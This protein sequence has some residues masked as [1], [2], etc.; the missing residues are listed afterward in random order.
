MDF[1]CVEFDLT[2]LR[3]FARWLWGVGCLGCRLKF[4]L[5]L[6]LRDFAFRGC[7]KDEQ[8]IPHESHSFVMGLKQK[9]KHADAEVGMVLGCFQK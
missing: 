5:A 3:S 1:P 7:H 9:R 2:N 4:L 8:Q 6:M